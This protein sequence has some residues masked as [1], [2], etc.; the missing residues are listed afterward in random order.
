MTSDQ[1]I[2]H[3]Y[4]DLT[5]AFPHPFDWMGLLAKP[6]F[7]RWSWHTPHR[8]VRAIFADHGFELTPRVATRYHRRDPDEWMHY[9]E[10]AG[11]KI[12]RKLRYAL[13][14]QLPTQH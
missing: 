9:G 1:D 11:T 5:A 3:L 6:P 12:T 8:R 13:L 14:H 4:H 7:W 2:D 10:D